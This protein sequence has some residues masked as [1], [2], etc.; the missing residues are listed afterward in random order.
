MQ[1]ANSVL[2]TGAAGLLGRAICKAL[3]REGYSIVVHYFTNESGANRLVD[4]LRGMECRAFSIG[5]DLTNT[6]E[7][8]RLFEV[9]DTQMGPLRAL[10]NNAGY[11]CGRYSVFDSGAE[12]AEKAMQVNFY[13]A[14]DCIHSAVQRMKGN[15]GAIVN[16]TT[17]AIVSGGYRLAHYVAA[18]SALSSYASSVAKEL[19]GHNIRINN[20]S[21]NIVNNGASLT[22]QELQR[23]KTLPMGRFC[24][25]AEVAETV[26]WLLSDKASY[27]SGADIPVTG[28]R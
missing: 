22:E 23:A 3:A 7:V 2:V 27:I 13:S 4:E 21:P 19:A 1:I 24:R 18:K 8:A 20:V 14:V 26:A 6:A 17:D 11:D 28:A 16:I 12:L 10:V 15:G 25:S 5:A 9:I